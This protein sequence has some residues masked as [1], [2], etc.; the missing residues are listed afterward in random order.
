M[1]NNNS[2]IR[3][4]CQ[5]AVIAALYA[6]L[7]LFVNAFGLANGAIQVRLSEALCILPVFTPSAVGGLFLGCIIANLLCA[8]PVWDIVF[9]SLATLI[10]AYL[11]YRM[12][13]IRYK[14]L[15]TLP[16]VLSNAIII[17]FVLKLV[18]KLDG[19]YWYFFAT[20]GLGELISCT[21]VGMLF[22]KLLYPHRNK[23]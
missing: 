20:V 7:T 17:P 13:N 16:P 4:M 5:S 15:C 10:G 6:S 18:Y 21:V 22:Y 8:S 1:T 3:F 9:G 14:T 12:R 2:K 11:T 23:L 19:A